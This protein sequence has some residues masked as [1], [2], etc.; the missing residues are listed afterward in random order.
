MQLIDAP[1][2]VLT[3]EIVG[4]LL[5]TASIT[6]TNP[7]ADRNEASTWCKTRKHG[8]ADGLSLTSAVLS[9]QG[10]EVPKPERGWYR[11]LRRGL[12]RLQRGT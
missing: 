2:R 4:A 11:R 5:V 9:W 10:F 1:T 6:T 8:Q 7:T 3:R 12:H